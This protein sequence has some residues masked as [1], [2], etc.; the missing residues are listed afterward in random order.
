MS[1]RKRGDFYQLSLILIDSSLPTI[2]T[3]IRM[4]DVGKKPYETT[5]KL[6]S[7]FH[8]LTCLEPKWRYGCK[9][10]KRFSAK[11]LSDKKSAKDITAKGFSLMR[12]WMKSEGEGENP[13][14][15]LSF[16]H[17]FPLKSCSL[18]GHHIISVK[19][20]QKKVGDIAFERGKSED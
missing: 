17:F 12:V 18:N 20:R 15:V 3:I 2:Y 14:A 9:W 6:M 19:V 5:K 13:F 4:K 8:K 11:I 1:H 10:A 7:F 16:A